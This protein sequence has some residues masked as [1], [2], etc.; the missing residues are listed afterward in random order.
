[1]NF[2]SLE[3]EQVWNVLVETIRRGR[4]N[5]S[6]VKTLRIHP[7]KPKLRDMNTY[8]LRGRIWELEG[9]R[10]YLIHNLEVC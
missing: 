6:E 4:I 3:T 7:G 5:G 8:K 9:Y 10:R 1:M 2:G